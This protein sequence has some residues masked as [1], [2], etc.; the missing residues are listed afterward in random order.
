MADREPVMTAF[1]QA[2][3]DYLRIRRAMG[4]RLVRDGKLLAQFI[5]F[6]GDQ[7][8][9]TITTELALQWA[10]LPS[11]KNPAWPA[12]RLT[13]VRRFAIYLQTIN[14]STQVPPTGLLPSGQRRATPYLYSDAEITALITAAQ[15]LSSPLRIATYQTLIALL[16][17]SGM[18]IGE[19]INLDRQDLDTRHGVLT[20]RNTKFGKSREIPLHPSTT[21]A[22]ATYQRRRD[23][24]LP[25]PSTPAVFIS[26][27]GTRLLHHNVGW[28]FGKLVRHA[29]LTPRSASCRPRVHDIRHTMAVRTIIDAYTSGQ[30]VQAQ[31][32]RLCTYLGH[33]DPGA[34]YWY[35]SAAP[36]LMAL[37]GERLERHLQ[38]PTS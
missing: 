1:E 33:L 31:L 17:V 4:Y 9:S 8:A 19:A 7:G 11:G 22:L 15:I 12:N 38:G 6:L 18:R 25:E 23:G 28:T 37:A 30:D 26:P 16:S 5:A 32:A 14:P 35:L 10:Q 24:W 36:E 20:I 13:V 29:G 27:A 3:G 2:L 21:Q 34:T